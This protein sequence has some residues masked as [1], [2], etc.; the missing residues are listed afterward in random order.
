MCLKKIGGNYEN[1]D[2]ILKIGLKIRE[3]SSGYVEINS[4]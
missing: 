1:Q 2:V 3:I 4:I